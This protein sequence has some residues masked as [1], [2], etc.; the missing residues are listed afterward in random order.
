[1]PKRFPIKKPKP[2]AID[3]GK[4][5]EK[6]VFGFSEVRPFSYVDSRN[7]SDFF[8]AF[9]GRL[10][11]L[12]GTDWNTVNTSGRHSFGWEKIEKSSMTTAAQAHMPNG[13]KS[14]LAF[15]AKGDNHAF[16]G[17]RDGNTFQIVF[18][19]SRFGDV[20]NHG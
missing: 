6:I 20:Y 16:L 18:I 13:M 1:M 10:K 3:I 17:F 2:L 8:I 4:G 9:L 7:D 14:L 12:C 5:C 15:R 11:K 19:E